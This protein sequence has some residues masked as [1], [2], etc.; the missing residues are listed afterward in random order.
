[1]GLPAGFTVR[2]PATDDLAAVAEV[3][4]ADDIDDVGEVVLDADFI[5]SAWNR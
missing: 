3:F 2:A 1:M 5:G 4:A